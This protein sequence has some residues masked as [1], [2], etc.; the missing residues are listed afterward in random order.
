MSAA[1]GQAGLDI[2]AANRDSIDLVILDLHLPGVD[3]FEI[4]SRIK[5]SSHS[6][7]TKILAITGYDTPENAQRIF[8][9]GADAYLAKPF[10]IESLNKKINDLL[11]LSS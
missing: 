7:R 4:C 6:L 2:Y 3:G 11:G 1:D 8:A 9:S 5:K 10:D